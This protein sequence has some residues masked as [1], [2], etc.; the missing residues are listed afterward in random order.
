MTIKR[1]PGRKVEPGLDGPVSRRTVSVDDLTWRRLV[2]LGG[3][4]ASKGIRDAARIAYERWQR[5]AT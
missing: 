3:G 1:T 4:N 2:A 5:G